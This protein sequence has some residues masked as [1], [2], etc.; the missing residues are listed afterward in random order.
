V[1]DLATAIALVFVI[2]GVFYSLFPQVAKRMGTQ[3]AGLSATMLR[4]TGLVAALVGVA[5]VWLIRR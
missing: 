4:S 3:V 5:A 1:R 2:E